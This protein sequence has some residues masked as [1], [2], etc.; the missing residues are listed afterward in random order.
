MDRVFIA[1]S[2]HRELKPSTNWT[3]LAP[4]FEFVTGW[5]RPLCPLGI[6][7]RAIQGLEHAWGHFAD[8]ASLHLKFV[9]S[10][11]IEN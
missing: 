4:M 9:E 2:S 5:K 11:V 6:R 3:R 1:F 10:S 8:S 7:L